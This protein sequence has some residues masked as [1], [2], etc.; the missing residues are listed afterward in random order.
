MAMTADALQTMMMLRQTSPTVARNSTGSDL[1]F[2]AMVPKAQLP[3]F[4]ETMSGQQSSVGF[5]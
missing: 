3:K 4:R 5:G 2:L 1:S